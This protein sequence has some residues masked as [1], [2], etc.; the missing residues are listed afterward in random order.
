MPRRPVTE[1]TGQTLRGIDAYWSI[2]L[3]LH[4]TQGGFTLTEV[5]MRTNAL[6]AT[7][8]DYIRRLVK[9]GYLEVAASDGGETGQAKVY[10]L[11]KPQSEAPR[12][13]RDGTLAEQGRARE[14]MWRTARIIKEFTYRDLAIQASTEE[15]PVAPIDAQDYCKHLA[16][17]GYLAVRQEARPG[18]LAI[19]RFLATR[20][21]GPK[22]PMVQR[23]KSVFD[24]NLNKVMWTAKE[25]T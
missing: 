13:R 21:T 24:P 5:E 22:A 16:K 14:Q 18:H 10:V 25:G 12:P 2:I 20:Y 8:G 1:M 19:Y 17:A 7:V 4:K 6:R 23:V 3:D 15:C 9:A 11:A